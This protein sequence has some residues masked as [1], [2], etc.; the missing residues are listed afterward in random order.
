MVSA[1][2][3]RAQVD[4]SLVILVGLVQAVIYP[5]FL[6]VAPERF[7]AWHRTYTGRITGFVVPLMF[8][9]VGLIAEAT[10]R[11]PRAGNLLAAGAVAIAWVSTFTLSVPC[12]AALTSGGWDAAVIRRLVATNWIRVFAWTTAW[13]AGRFAVRC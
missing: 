6:E 7:P 4:V 1:D 2:T 13:L 10:W 5:S 11:C 12:H 3:L 8:L 9:Q